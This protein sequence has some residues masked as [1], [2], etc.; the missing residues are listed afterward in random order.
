[1][2]FTEPA[3]TGETTPLEFIVATE[4]FEEFQVIDPEAV[5][6]NVILSP[7]QTAVRPV[8]TGVHLN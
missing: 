5:V 6:A 4:L 2:K 3:D 1:M 7:I 8:I